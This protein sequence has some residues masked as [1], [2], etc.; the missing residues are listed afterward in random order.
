MFSKEDMLTYEKF[1]KNI[2]MF[3]N[4]SLD[5]V[6]GKINIFYDFHKDKQ[7]K[8]TNYNR[9]LLFSIS[10][11]KPFRIIAPAGYRLI[12][13]K[14]VPNF[15]KIET[16]AIKLSRT[17]ISFRGEIPLNHSNGDLESGVLVRVN[18]LEEILKPRKDKA[19]ILPNG[20]MYILDNEG[21]QLIKIG[22]S[23]GNIDLTKYAKKPEDIDIMDPQLKEFIEEVIK[24]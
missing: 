14:S 2:R 6:Y 18:S 13:F 9:E 5:Y 17:P 12:Q 7:G 19:Y 3:P 1:N 10:T 24:E 23:D 22:G 21:K 20:E 16:L 8:N 15:E 4:F 11:L